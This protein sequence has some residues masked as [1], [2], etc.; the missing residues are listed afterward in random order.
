MPVSFEEA[1]LFPPFSLTLG[2]SL[3]TTAVTQENIAS[4]A[5]VVDTHVNHKQFT[6]N[7]SQLWQHAVADQSDITAKKSHGDDVA[8]Y[9]RYILSKTKPSAERI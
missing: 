1:R 5:N 3:T 9:G 4:H 8:N 2:W 7:T 6:R